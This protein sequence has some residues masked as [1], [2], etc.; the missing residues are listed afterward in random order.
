MDGTQAAPAD[1][2]EWVEFRH[3]GLLKGQRIELASGV[4]AN[5]GGNGSGKTTSLQL[6]RHT[7][8]CPPRGVDEKVFAELFK[9][10]LKRGEVTVGFVAGGTRYTATRRA[11]GETNITDASGQIVDAAVDGEFFG[12]EMYSQD[13]LKTIGLVQS[14]Q[15]PMIDAFRVSEIRRLTESVQETIGR[16]NANKDEISRKAQ[17]LAELEDRIAD[18]PS[19][20]EALKASG[21]LTSDDDAAAKRM[22]EGNDAR[23]RERG[24]VAEA[25]DQL[26]AARTA[27]DAFDRARVRRSGDRDRPRPTTE[28]DKILG[29]VEEGVRAAMTAFENASRMMQEAL[30]RSDDLVAAQAKLLAA[31]HAPLDA[32]YEKWRVER[33][34]QRQR[35]L[36]CDDTS[37]AHRDEC[38][39]NRG[40]RDR[41]IQASG[42]AS[43]DVRQASADA[44][45][46][47][48]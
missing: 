42:G 29:G 27:L 8:G 45:G 16:L 23:I 32:Q 35:L 46:G 18:L 7:L 33:G 15:L 48:L 5:I 2:I 4:T 20:E 12:I 6:A 28:A 17:E 24:V 1:R 43:P 13:E 3:D 9:S 26:R 19:V 11:D 10:N 36:A 22:I 25:K 44:G 39:P 37:R 41:H 40:D 47:D 14:A 30:S 21:D 38:G 34:E 31:E